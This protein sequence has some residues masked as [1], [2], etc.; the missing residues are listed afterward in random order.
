MSWTPVYLPLLGTES[1]L[2]NTSTTE[3]PYE[4]LSDCLTNEWMNEWMHAWILNLCYDR[5]L[6]GQSV[7]ENKAPS[8]GLGPDFYYC[9]MVAD[10][11]LWRALSDERTGL[12]LKIAAG[13]RQ[14]S[15]SR[16]RVP[17]DSR[18]YFTV[19]DSRPPFSSPPTTRMATVEVLDPACTL[20]A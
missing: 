20:K 16:V 2:I 13:T 15:H 3:L 4:R 17:W 1:Y 7:L 10:L 6:V 14:R 12:S 19:S 5:R 8:W 9:Q 18:P 11:L